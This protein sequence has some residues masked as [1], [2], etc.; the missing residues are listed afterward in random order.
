VQRDAITLSPFQEA[1]AATVLGWIRSPE[2]AEAWASIHLDEV[3]VERLR[4]WHEDPDVH[5]YVGLAR[6]GLVGYGEVW[7]DAEAR[8]AELARIVVAPELR[9]RGLGRRLTRLLAERAQDAGF[10]EIWLRVVASNSAALAAYRSAGFVR[11]AAAQ[12]R[13]FNEGQPREYVWMRLGDRTATV[14]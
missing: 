10:A 3:G 1:H 13:L 2:E 9:G 6:G 11:A 7:E 14:R 5:P 12:E 4:R 8:E